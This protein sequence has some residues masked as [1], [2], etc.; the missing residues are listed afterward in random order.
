MWGTSAQ[1]DQGQTGHCVGFAWAQ[2]GDC[3]PVNDVFTNSDA[4]AIYYEAKVID[5][6]PQ[7]ENGTSVHSG[8]KA[9]LARKR[10]GA[11]AWTQDLEE[12]K[13]FV[14]TQG[15]LVVGTYWTNDMFNPDA[16]NFVH[17]TGAIAGGH[18][19][20]ICGYDRS[21]NV[22]RFQNNWG[23]NWAEHGFFYMSANEWFSIFT[24]NGDG[25]ACAGVELA[26]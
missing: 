18:A 8:A 12:I 20:Y 19:Y 25:E 14:L 4:H 3:S 13:T 10:I 1:L 9:M 5:R 23:A 21:T 11:Y 22:L 6:E 24:K 16:H 7:A 26:L 17:P 2:W 15:P